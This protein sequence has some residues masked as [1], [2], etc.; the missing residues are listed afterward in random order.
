LN[1]A[2]IH[3]WLVDNTKHKFDLELIHIGSILVMLEVGLLLIHVY[4]TS[5]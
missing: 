1:K 3:Y 2:N 5:S 4:L